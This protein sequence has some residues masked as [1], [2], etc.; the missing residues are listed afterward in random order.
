MTKVTNLNFKSHIEMSY[1][2]MTNSLEAT[3][4]SNSLRAIGSSNSL[5]FNIF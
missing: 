3:R 1:R 2:N 4:S 5:E